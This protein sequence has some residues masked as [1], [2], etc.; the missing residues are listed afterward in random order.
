MLYC[1]VRLLTEMDC[2]WTCHATQRNGEEF[3]ILNSHS[4]L[5]T[6]KSVSLRLTCRADRDH[7]LLHLHLSERF[8]NQL[9]SRILL[10]T[11]QLWMRC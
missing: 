11:Y 7:S 5:I 10:V 8:I 3:V 2:K 1:L 9:G 6:I 4:V